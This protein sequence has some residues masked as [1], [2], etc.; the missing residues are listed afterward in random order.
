MVR[1]IIKNDNVKYI[2]LLNKISGRNFSFLDSA[3]VRLKMM[4]AWLNIMG[5][6]QIRANGYPRDFHV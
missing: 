3:E 4:P 2:G 1:S 5:N 6:T